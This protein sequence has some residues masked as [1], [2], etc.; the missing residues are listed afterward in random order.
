LGKEFFWKAN[1]L[2]WKKLLLA[3]G[4]LQKELFLE[5][6]NIVQQKFVAR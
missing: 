4:L 3:S 1:N 2:L 5:I 6:K